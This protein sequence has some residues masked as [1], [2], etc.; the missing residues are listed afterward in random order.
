M[1]S[2]AFD[3]YLLRTFVSVCQHRSLSGAANQAGRAQSALS[4][5]IRRLEEQ[6]GQR[7]LRRTGRGVVPTTEGELLLSYAIRILALGD[8]V[9]ARLKERTLMGNV[10]IGLS[11]NVAVSTLPAALGRLR[12]TC[13]HVHLEISVEHGDALAERWH[14]GALD[15]AIGVSSAFTADPLRSWNVD[16]YWVCAIDDDIDPQKPL[17]VIVYAEPCSWR[18][19]MFDALLQAGRDF[20][21][22]VTSP[23]IGVITAAVENGL[24]VA[25]LP[26]ESIRPET[27]RVVSLAGASSGPVLSVNY[28][29]FVVH[30][31]NDSIRAAVSLLSDSLH[32]MTRPIFS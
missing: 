15:V 21:V 5:Q 13:P 11:E 20:R 14:E 6:L 16:L 4:A 30:R 9:A 7:L 1:I 22:A 10:R 29:L 3:P 19:L 23:N 31:Q 17:D 25:L 32:S 18:R 24:G 26:A 2:D 12:R 27:M 28:G 8:T